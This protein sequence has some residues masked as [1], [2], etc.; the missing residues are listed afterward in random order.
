MSKIQAV[1][2][3]MDGVL[4]DSMPYH[5]FAWY[6]ALRKYGVRVSVQDIYAHEGEKWERTLRF[7]LRQ[8][9]LPQDGQLMRKI[10]RCKQRLFHKIFKRYLM[11]GV[12]ELA[13]ELQKQKYALG[14]VSGTPVADIKRLLPPRLL[15]LFACLVGGDSVSRG[16]PDPEPY[17][18]GAAELNLRPAECLVIENAPLGIASAKAAGC[19]CL[20]VTTSLP[21]EQLRQADQVCA[22]PA[23]RKTLCYN[24][25]NL[26]RD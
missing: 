13:A 9:G 12:P 22:L 11:P 2:F 5:F 17:R 19:Y 10:F 20:A 6:E 15:K 18:K 24:L 25:K 4:V 8:N 3:D 21:A 14:V 1:L 7:F 23:L 26:R 16:K